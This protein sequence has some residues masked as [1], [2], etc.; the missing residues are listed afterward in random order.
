MSGL[1]QLL[2]SSSHAGHVDFLEK[3]S[4]YGDFLI[5]GLLLDSVSDPSVHCEL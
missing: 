2:N 4:Q 3:A 1:F 5:V